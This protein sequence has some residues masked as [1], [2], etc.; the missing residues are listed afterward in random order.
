MT[1]QVYWD[2][3][4]LETHP[5]Q[6][7]QYHRHCPLTM[8]RQTWLRRMCHFPAMI[9]ASAERTHLG[10]APIPLAIANFFALLVATCHGTRRARSSTFLVGLSFL[11]AHTFINEHVT[12]VL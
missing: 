9:D 8:M 12:F 10:V 5:R 6:L 4:S 1:L 2:F 11:E 3:G 7:R